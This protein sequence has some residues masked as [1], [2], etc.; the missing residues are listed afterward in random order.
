MTLRPEGS[1]PSITSR[2]LDSLLTRNG[3]SNNRDRLL[4]ARCDLSR[5]TPD[6]TGALHA[7]LLLELQ[8]QGALPLRLITPSKS[9]CP[10]D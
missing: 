1:N 4:T 6:C 2:Q 8:D 9:N 5:A 3:H 10:F 7:R